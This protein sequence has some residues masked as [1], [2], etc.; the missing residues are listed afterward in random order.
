[1]KQ[2]VEGRVIGSTEG[3]RER[4]VWMFWRK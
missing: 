2:P 1:M 3:R 4:R